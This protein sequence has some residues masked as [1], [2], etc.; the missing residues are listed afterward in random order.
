MLY[1]AH[2]V[3]IFTSESPAVVSQKVFP[4]WARYIEPYQSYH[5]DSLWSPFS[6]D[7]CGW[8][9]SSCILKTYSHFTMVNPT[10]SIVSWKCY[11]KRILCE[12]LQVN[13]QQLY[14]EKLF[15]FQHGISN[16]INPITTMLYEAHF[17]WM[18]A[19]QQLYAAIG[20]QQWK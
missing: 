7:V 17:V 18:F 11:K 3:R 20:K 14:P 19:Q 9:R 8:I 2:F 6:M 16:L 15:L 5:K 12:W 10:F 1:R 13:H 4:I